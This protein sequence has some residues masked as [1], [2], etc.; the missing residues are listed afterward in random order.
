MSNSTKLL[1]EGEGP[2]RAALRLTFIEMEKISFSREIRN[3][4]VDL[5]RELPLGI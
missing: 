2:Q 3:S 5:K 1:K 4:N